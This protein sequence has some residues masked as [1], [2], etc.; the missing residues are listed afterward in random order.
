MNISLYCR[1]DN[2]RICHKESGHRCV[3]KEYCSKDPTR[4]D[5]RKI[6]KGQIIYLVTHGECEEEIKSLSYLEA[7]KKIRRIKCSLGENVFFY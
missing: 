2:T 6:T 7:A 3:D 5:G 1:Y 4:F